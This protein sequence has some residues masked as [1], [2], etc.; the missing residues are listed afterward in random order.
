MRHQEETVMAKRKHTPVVTLVLAAATPGILASTTANAAT[1]AGQLPNQ[2]QSISR[3]GDSA[4]KLEA[5][6]LLMS[7]LA[8]MSPA[9]KMGLAGA[10]LPRTNLMILAAKNT[11]ANCS[12]PCR[13]TLLLCPHK[14]TVPGG[15]PSTV[16]KKAY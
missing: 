13:K 14:T 3:E 8:Q 6:Q 16:T 5:Q 9:E 4:A 11:A 12:N 2:V 10:R 15:C 1:A 7:E